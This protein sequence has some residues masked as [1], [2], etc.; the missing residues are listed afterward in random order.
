MTTIEVFEPLNIELAP[1][2][3]CK[4]MNWNDAK[5]YA[6]S[7]NIDGRIGWRLPTDEEMGILLRDNPRF[8]VLLLSH[9]V[10]VTR[11]YKVNNP[12][13]EYVV[14]KT[15]NGNHFETRKIEKVQYTTVVRDLK[16]D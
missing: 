16:D 14:F 9:W 3:Y 12:V 6:F 2:Q 7:L 15:D 8:N 13:K 11:S 10:T 1:E 4:M 5:L